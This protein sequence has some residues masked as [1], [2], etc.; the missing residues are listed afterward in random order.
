MCQAVGEALDLTVEGYVTPSVAI[1]RTVEPVE[2]TRS[3]IRSRSG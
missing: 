3:W 2:K 1:A